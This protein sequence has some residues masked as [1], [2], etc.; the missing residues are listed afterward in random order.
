MK[1]LD[2]YAAEAKRAIG[3][4]YGRTAHFNDRRPVYVPFETFIKEHW[5]RH[6][7]A[8]PTAGTIING[9]SVEIHGFIQDRR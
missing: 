6:P 2:E 7:A 1:T 8:D 4:W 9:E 3:R 5:H